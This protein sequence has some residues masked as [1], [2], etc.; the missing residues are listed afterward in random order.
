MKYLAMTSICFLTLVAFAAS[1]ISAQQQF[2][3]PDD[4][5]KALKDAT[6]TK[7]KTAL[8]TIFG[9]RLKEFLSGDAVA[10]E[11][12]FQEFAGRLS[13]SAKWEKD[14]D[15]KMTLLIGED[16]WP[17]A[18]PLVKL[19]ERWH[20]DTAAGIEEIHNRRIGSNEL[21]AML[22][23]QAYVLAQF[24]YFNGEDR[25]GDQVSEYAQKIAS[26]PGKQDG[27]FWETSANEDESPLGPLFAYAASEGYKPKRTSTTRTAAPFHGYN[28]KVLYRQGPSAPGGRYGYV[29]NGNM[30][31]G[32]AL[33][34]YPAGYGNS[35]VMTFVVN[36]E[37]RVYQKDLGSRTSV[38]AAAMTEYNP[39]IT[40]SL[41]DMNF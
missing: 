29:I 34:A 28:F 10:D 11:N 30:I 25:D 2:A 19:G 27:L 37:G 38:I 31:A 5:L 8:G 6:A 16:E 3:N 12:D 41:A 15:Q 39:D 32:F 7:N 18:A 35:G 26:A 9:S 23:C 21:D 20:F 40:W 24:E 4:A 22:L 36:Q 14:S 1:S 13:S 17:F 33:V